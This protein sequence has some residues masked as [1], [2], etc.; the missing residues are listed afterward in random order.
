MSEHELPLDQR[1]PADRYRLLAARFSAWL[2]QVPDDAWDA[3]SPCEGWTARDV[4]AHV[5][6]SQRGFVEGAGEQLPPA[7]DPEQDPVGAFAAT[8]EGVQALLDDP[9]RAGREF[10]GR[11]G[12]GT[13]EGAVGMFHCVDLVV[14]GWDLA[15]ATGLDTTVPSDQ[16]AWVREKVEGLSDM[17]RSPGA[18][19]PEVDPP[20]GADETTRTMAFL[21]R[22]PVAAR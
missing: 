10:D 16:L 17:A 21:G 20:E 13:I 9:E 2:E 3:P 22:R 8:R 12:R 1:T 7:P 15:Q 6:Q 11:T 14:H 5:V 19:G 18:F 4:V